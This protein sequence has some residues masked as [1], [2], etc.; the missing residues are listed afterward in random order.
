LIQQLTLVGKRNTTLAFFTSYERSLLKTAWGSQKARLNRDSF[1]PFGSCSLCL[2]AARDPVA[3][4]EGDL[5]CRECA[6]NNLL[7]QRKEI[8]R[9]EKEW[10]RQKGDLDDSKK[11][12][13]EDE[14]DKDVEDFERVQMGLQSKNKRKAGD[15]G[16]PDSQLR[17]SKQKIDQNTDEKVCPNS[18]YRL[19]QLNTNINSRRF[20][21]FQLHSGFHHRHQ[22]LDQNR[23]KTNHQN[24][25]VYVHHL[26]NRLLTITR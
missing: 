20:L 21:K 3:C 11:L 26:R 22:T 10:I 25:R 4:P 2:L 13:E 24:C 1:L 5:F 16:E 6:I 18:H 14:H 15:L 23:L 12:D 19:G 8:T 7:A 17:T 9:L